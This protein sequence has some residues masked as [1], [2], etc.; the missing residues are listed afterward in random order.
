M[1]D[2][3]S[4]RPDEIYHVSV[5]P[6]YDKKLE[7]SR[8]DF[9][10][11]VFKTRDVDCVVTTG[12]LELMM[13]EIGWD[14]ETRS[15]S[16]TQAVDGT[17]VS[18]PVKK[19]LPTKDLP[20]IRIPELLIHPGTS[21]GSYL[22]AILHH[23]IAISPVPLSLSIKAV[24]NAADYEEYVLRETPPA[25][26]PTENGDALRTTTT[27]RVVFKGV[28]CYGFRNLQN[29]V[30]KVGR[31]R[32]VRVGSGAAGRLGSSGG[33]GAGRG[34][35]RLRAARKGQTAEDGAS[36]VAEDE[37]RKF[38]YV[39]VMA[40]PGGCVNGGGQLRPPAVPALAPTTSGDVDAEGYKRDW[41][42]EGVAQGVSAKWGDREWTKKVEEAYWRDT[43]RV[44]NDYKN[45]VADQ[46]VDG[47][48]EE[49]GA[50][51]DAERIRL[52][53]TEYRAVESDVIGLAVKW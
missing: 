50:D 23:L 45:F 38:D 4:R 47:I 34:V 28:K 26:D 48:M 25:P 16:P 37:E 35:R 8:Q 12:E 52:F 19:N 17:K 6:C 29:V 22:H 41:D 44:G 2:K 11:D 14:L 27:G 46:L 3:V 20:E 13:K 7:A 31:E 51:D 32:G 40:C 1:V 49:L 53:R 33:A 15:L 10:D 42:G 5:M 39:E 18:I 36:G 30:R 21:S 9:Y 43:G 24:R